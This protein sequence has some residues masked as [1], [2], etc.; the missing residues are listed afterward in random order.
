M[1]NRSKLIIRT[2]FVLFIDCD[3]ISVFLKNMKV[4]QNFLIIMNCFTSTPEPVAFMQVSILLV[5][6]LRG[7]EGLV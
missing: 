1:I 3:E 7:D 6:Q 5:F 4:K 2:C